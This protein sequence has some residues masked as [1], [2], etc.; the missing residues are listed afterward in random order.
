[1]N[2]E[3][4]RMKLGWIHV[5]C[6]LQA[7]TVTPQSHQWF[8]LTT[9]LVHLVIIAL[10]VHDTQQNFLVLW[11]L[12]AIRHN[13]SMNL[14]VYLVYHVMLVQHQACQNQIC[15][16]LLAIIVNQKLLVHSLDKEMMLIHVH[17]VS[18][19]LR[20]QLIHYPVNQAHTI[21]V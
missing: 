6:V 17:L 3:C 12:L 1:M 11:A 18:I 7:I 9:I 8:C 16:V 5:R 20:V 15:Y 4:T 13:L 21:L 19:A 14:N 10:K 2:Q